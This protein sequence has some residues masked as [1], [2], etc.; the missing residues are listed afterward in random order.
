MTRD[1]GRPIRVVVADDHPVYRDGLRAML[2]GWRGAELVGE[3][4]DGEEAVRL[5]AE[6]DPDVMLMDVQMP[7]RSGV[8][9]TAAI[10]AA[11]PDVAVVVLTMFEENATVAAALRAGARGYLVKGASGDDLR[12]A[13]VAAAEGA[14]IL[15]RGIA[16]RLGT[17]LDS[18]GRDRAFPELT[19]REHEI[20]ELIAEGRANADI[21]RRLGLT[22]KTV[23]NYVSTILDKLAVRGRSEAIVR[24][25]EAGLGVSGPGG[26]TG[27]A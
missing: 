22:E 1:A 26:R 19:E 25:R 23:R 8:D 24:A 17:I 12:A 27:P 11:H 20:L 4:A 3:A 15:G 14:A 10:V 18:A 13:I 16:S 2:A 9:A 6:L 5:A 7:G 21:A